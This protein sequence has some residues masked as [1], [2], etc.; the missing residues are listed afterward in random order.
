MN[1]ITGAMLE[2]RANGISLDIL[3]HE[4]S[5]GMG[6][7]HIGTYESLVYS[8]PGSTGESTIVPSGNTKRE[9]YERLSAML[10]GFYQQRRHKKS[11]FVPILAQLWCESNA[12]ERDIPAAH[13]LTDDL[14]A[15]A[16]RSA[17]YAAGKLAA[18]M[19]TLRRVFGETETERWYAD[20]MQRRECVCN[21]Q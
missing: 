2:E 5:H 1:R 4:H 12:A 8:D 6:G 19:L 20:A 15:E 14:R 13:P 9:T 21:A 10:Q 18:T 11:D 17:G 16:L 7:F 3:G